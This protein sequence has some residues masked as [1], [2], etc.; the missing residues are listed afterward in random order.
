MQLAVQHIRKQPR[1]GRGPRHEIKF[2]F[3]HYYVQ[4]ALAWMGHYCAPDP[5]YQH[6][7][8][9][10]LYFDTRRLKALH[11]K[12]ESE[13]LKCK[14]RV[15]WYT[16]TE[17]T[18]CSEYAFL[19]IKSK[20][21]HRSFKKRFRLDIDVEELNRYPVETGYRLD[22]KAL[23]DDEDWHQFSGMHPLVVIRYVRRRFIEMASG[24]RVSMDHHIGVTHANPAFPFPGGPGVLPEA[25]VEVKGTD[26]RKL[27]P[28]LHG[29]QAFKLRKTAFSKYAECVTR[30]LIR[31]E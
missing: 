8:I 21:G 28:V 22:L 20:Q 1:H 2:V 27:P 25:I 15:R 6:N 31:G 19:E 3:P 7:V 4:P 12:D 9:K 14:V 30:L 23:A 10:S 24:L 29:L 11:E 5:A 13:F 26:A 17:N 18:S 16:D